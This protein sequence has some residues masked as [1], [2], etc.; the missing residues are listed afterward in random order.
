M[1][2]CCNGKKEIYLHRLTKRKKDIFKSSFIKAIVLNVVGC[3]GIKLYYT[4]YNIH[5]DMI[6]LYGNI[7]IKAYQSPVPPRLLVVRERY[8][9]TQM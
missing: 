5:T 9:L 1:H 7:K 4:I 2:F 6:A 3:Q 8:W